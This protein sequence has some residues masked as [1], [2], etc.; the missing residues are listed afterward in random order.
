[1][2]AMIHPEEIDGEFVFQLGDPEKV[3]KIK[4]RT[5]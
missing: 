4:M 1:M 5:V 2:V 3:G